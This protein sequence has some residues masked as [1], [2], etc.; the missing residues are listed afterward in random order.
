[1]KKKTLIILLIPIVAFCLVFSIFLLI[2]YQVS[3]VSM[4]EISIH[5]MSLSDHTFTARGTFVSSGKSF[6]SYTYTIDGCALYIT[7]YGGL[8]TKK[9]PNGDFSIT[10]E[11]IGL[12]NVSEVFLIHGKDAEQIYFMQSTK[13][14]LKKGFRP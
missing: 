11:D 8:V 2:L 13:S 7:I 1:M 10:I 6:R 3:S 5:N 4:S 14:L 12:Q 9:Y